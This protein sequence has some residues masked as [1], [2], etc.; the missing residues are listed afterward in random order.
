MTATVLRERMPIYA[1][2][3]SDILTAVLDDQDSPGCIDHAGID[4]LLGAVAEVNALMAYYFQCTSIP[5]RD[6][7]DIWALV[8]GLGTRSAVVTTPIRDRIQICASSLSGMLT[9]V[10]DDQNSPTPIDRSAIGDL[11]DPVNKVNALL[12]HHFHLGLI[13]EGDIADIRAMISGLV[14]DHNLH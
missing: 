11:L 12:V 4:N 14:S 13:P 10:C 8:S 9:A 2:A 6:M 5:E 3:L 1:A 7:A